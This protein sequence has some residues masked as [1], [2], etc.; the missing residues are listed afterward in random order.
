TKADILLGENTNGTADDV[1]MQ[2]R[3]PNTNELKGTLTTP[4]SDPTTDGL[5]SDVVNVNLT[6]SASPGSESDVFVLQ[7]SF[8]SVAGEAQAAQGGFLRIDWLNPNGGGTGIPQWQ[9]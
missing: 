2:W 5:I 8:G 9:N 7:M 4:P 3:K 6:G 1:T